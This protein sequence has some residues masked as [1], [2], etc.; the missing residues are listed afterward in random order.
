MNNDNPVIRAS[1]NT[2]EEPENL[3]RDQDP[4][5]KSWE[6]LREYSGL[7][8]NF[9]RRVSRVV[10]KAIGD[11]AYLDAANAMHSGQDS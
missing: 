1:L 9:K 6:S 3:F 2:Q 8:Q 7:D 10:N 11:E 5:T 4:F